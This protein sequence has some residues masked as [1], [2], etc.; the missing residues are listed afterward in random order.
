MTPP[1]LASKIETILQ[2]YASIVEALTEFT[3]KSECQD[4]LGKLKTVLQ[5][6]SILKEGITG[7][8]ERPK[9]RERIG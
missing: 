7:Q 9:L 3:D 5:K 1:T 8:P 2:K 4:C 6:Y